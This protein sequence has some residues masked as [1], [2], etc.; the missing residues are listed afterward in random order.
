MITL[1]KHMKPLSLECLMRTIN[2]QKERF[3]IYLKNTFSFHNPTAPFCSL[4][5]KNLIT[6]QEKSLTSETMSIM[7]EFIL[8]QVLF[9]TF[10]GGPALD[11]VNLKNAKV[12][13]KMLKSNYDQS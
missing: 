11:L 4:Y 10:H 6:L 1:C 3:L 2:H 5:L 8:M 12:L 9:I 13:L 7:H